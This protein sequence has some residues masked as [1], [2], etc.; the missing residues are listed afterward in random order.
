MT[1]DEKEEGDF[2]EVHPTF[3]STEIYKK[4]KFYIYYKN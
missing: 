2:H 1:S 4:K 3:Q